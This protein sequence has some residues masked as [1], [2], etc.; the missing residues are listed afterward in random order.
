MSEKELA[1]AK[2]VLQSR[3]LDTKSHIDLEMLMAN[4]NQGTTFAKTV[5]QFVAGKQ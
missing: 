3:S 2:F 1:I 5:G 4:R